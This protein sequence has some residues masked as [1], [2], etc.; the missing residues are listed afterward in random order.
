M[1]MFNIHKI[2]HAYKRL[3]ESMGWKVAHEYGGRRVIQTNHYNDRVGERGQISQEQLKKLYERAIDALKRSKPKNE[4]QGEYLIYS[5]E[6]KQ[7]IVVEWRKHDLGGFENKK[8]NMVLITYLQRKHAQPNSPRT[9]KVVVESFSD[10]GFSDEFATYIGAV[11]G[12]TEQELTDTVENGDLVNIN[13][14]EHLGYRDSCATFSDGKLWD[15][16]MYVIEVD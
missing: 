1:N 4:K 7:G 9:T 13:R 15:V 8:N 5:K 3:I 12:I 11:C 14:G 10:A 16:N 2:R 6:F